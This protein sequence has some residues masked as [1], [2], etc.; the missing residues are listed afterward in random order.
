[1]DSLYKLMQLN[2]INPNIINDSNNIYFT[3]EVINYIINLRLTDFRLYGIIYLISNGLLEKIN[4]KDEY[5]VIRL[6]KRSNTKEECIN[7]CNMIL[8]L[9]LDETLNVLL[10]REKEVKETSIPVLVKVRR[11]L[12]VK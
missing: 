8:T 11:L 5:K 9:S 1:M 3:K 12:K 7:I 2:N 4:P 6:I 10:A